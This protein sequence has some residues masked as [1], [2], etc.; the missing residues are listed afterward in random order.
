ML[1]TRLRLRTDVMSKPLIE[2][3]GKGLMFRMLD[4]VVAAGVKRAIVNVTYLAEQVEGLAEVSSAPECADRL[5]RLR[6]CIAARREHLKMTDH[7]AVT[8]TSM[9]EGDIE[10]F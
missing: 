10:L 2:G 9:V 7:R 3:V 1:G 4:L 6:Q 8:Q 5:S